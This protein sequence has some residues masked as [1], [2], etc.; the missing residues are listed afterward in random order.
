MLRALVTVGRDLVDR[1]ST[2][3][4]RSIR[5]RR[6]ST[7]E[8]EAVTRSRQT[9][10]AESGV[11][12]LR[13]ATTLAVKQAE[14]AMNS[15]GSVSGVTTGLDRPQREDRRHAP[16]GSDDPRRPSGHGQDLARHQHRVQRRAALDA[17]TWTTGSPEEKSI[18]AQVAF[19]SL[20]MSADQLATR[21]LSEQSRDRLGEAAHRARSARPN[22][23]SSRAPRRD[24]EKLPL[25][26]DDTPGL[27]I[28]RAAHAR[29]AAAA[30]STRSGWSSSTIS[31]CC[32]GSGT[33]LGRRPRAGNL[34]DQPRAE[35]AGQG[36]QRAGAGAVAAEPRGRKPRGQAPAAV[37]SARIGLDRAG[38]GHR[39]VRLSR[40][41]LSR[42]QG[43][44]APR[45]ATRRPTTSTKYAGVAGRAA[46]RGEH[47]RAD[48]RQAAPRRD[49]IGAIC[50][51]TGSSPSSAIS[52]RGIEPL[53]AS[54]SSGPFEEFAMTV[55][56]AIYCSR[57]CDR[58]GLLDHRRYWRRRSA[59]PRRP[60][61]H[62]HEIWLSVES[63]IFATSP[64]CDAGLASDRGALAFA[65]CCR[66]C[67]TIVTHRTTDEH[68]RLPTSPPVRW[69][70]A[71]SYRQV[72]PSAGARAR[73]VAQRREIAVVQARASA[74]FAPISGRARGVADD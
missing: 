18:G 71:T 40:R 11:K 19:F 3:A 27:T 29:A 31:S 52:R 66:S 34:G 5:A 62:A 63:A 33:Q 58:A 30:R 22:S 60:R 4:R 61:Q 57:C 36:S 15:G 21:I 35:D 59:R 53:R 6:S 39:A 26:I 38:R 2:P 17:T 9:G 65:P 48:H 8:D 37:G 24:L 51:S 68:E 74:R 23:S 46:A 69:R 72:V 32:T 12:T 1:R 41:I 10:G 50:G 20:E 43:A 47:G 44:Q 55:A 25:F 56:D 49:G 28:A 16:L 42:L 70:S 54:H 73:C 64:R 45:T 14:R 67:A 7:A 13:A